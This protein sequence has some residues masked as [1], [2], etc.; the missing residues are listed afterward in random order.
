MQ[1][2][3]IWHFYLH[4]QGLQVHEIQWNQKRSVQKSTSE[5][6]PDMEMAL[7]GDIQTLIL[8]KICK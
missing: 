8:M 5:C 1:G 7:Y 4:Q 6:W 2:T 3:K